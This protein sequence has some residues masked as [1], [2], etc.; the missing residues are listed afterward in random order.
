MDKEK[1]KFP[2]NLAHHWM[3]ESRQGLR[4]WHGIPYDGDPR[5]I[6]PLGQ[7]ALP[8]VFPQHDYARAARRKAQRCSASQR[9]IK[10]PGRT[11]SPP[12]AMSGYISRRL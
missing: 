12:T 3:I 4:K 7:D 6:N 10:L 2:A 5:R 8:H 1:T 11:I 9:S